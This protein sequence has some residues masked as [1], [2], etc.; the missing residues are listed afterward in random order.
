LFTYLENSERKKMTS[1]DKTLLLR[2]SDHLAYLGDWAATLSPDSTSRLLMD[3]C[4]AIRRLAG[5]CSRHRFSEF[6]D[7]SERVLGLMK[8][9]CILYPLLGK[10]TCKKD[11]FL[12]RIEILEDT[13]SSIK[14][15]KSRSQ[16]RSPS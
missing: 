12:K 6:L 9:Y 7:G 16:S 8:Q 10:T 3:V 14:E 15:A 13:I 5:V 4:N 2:A 1:K 11:V